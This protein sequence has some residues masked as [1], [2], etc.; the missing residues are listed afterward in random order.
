MEQPIKLPEPYEEN[1][2]NV[3][4]NLVFCDSLEWYKDNMEAP[5]S[6][7]FDVLFSETSTV[8]KLQEISDDMEHD[9]RLRLLA[10]RKQQA[11][12]HTP[13]QKELLAVIVEVGLENGLDTLA[14]FNDGTARYINYTE[15][16]LVWETTNDQSDQLTRDLFLKSQN[17][18]EQIGTWDKPRLPAPVTGNVRITFLVSDGLYF[19]EGPVDALFNDP[20][21][22]PALTAA[23]YLMKYITEHSTESY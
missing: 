15:K 6:F 10:Y 12:G 16:V 22:G 8:P 19:G 20:M 5:Y 9:T 13:G 4:Y 11:L 17:I 3:I 14:S 23:A 1:Y 7:P 18:V 21:A 2:T